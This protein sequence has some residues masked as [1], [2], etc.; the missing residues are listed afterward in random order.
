[1]VFWARYRAANTKKAHRC[2]E[3]MFSQVYKSCGVA[4]TASQILFLVCLFIVVPSRIEAAGAAEEHHHRAP[5]F[6]SY[7]AIADFDG[8]QKPDL[9]T[10][11]IQKGSSSR[12]TLYSIRFQLSTGDSQVFGVTAPAGGLQIVARD[13]NGDN[14]LDVLVS[15]AW[16]HEQ[17]AV[18][19]NDGHGNFTL[20]E[21]DAFPEDSWPC[22]T[23]WKSATIPP[24]ESAALVRFQ[25]SAGEF[26][27][28]SEFSGF[29]SRPGNA[30]LPMTLGS[31]RLLHFSLLG[32]APP[33]SFFLLKHC[34]QQRVN[35]AA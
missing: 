13:V 4:L 24:C 22:E 9:A 25:Y 28:R 20:A 30:R 11:E 5:R 15:T 23:L 26:E 35:L 2:L 27:E 32:R 34:I 3:F 19:L 10:V 21:P 17:V 18:L 14:A 16:L 7:F 12:S 29:P 8:D 33:A 31:T 6:N 1:M